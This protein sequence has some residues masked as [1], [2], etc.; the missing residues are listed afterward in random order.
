MNVYV[1]VCICVYIYNYPVLLHTH[2][3]TLHGRV[4]SCLLISGSFA[5]LPL[6]L[7]EFRVS[8]LGVPIVS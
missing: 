7:G 4:H 6:L 2:T 5:E 1:Y 3:L 8:D